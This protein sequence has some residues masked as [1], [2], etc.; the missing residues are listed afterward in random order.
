M[1]TIRLE[2]GGNGRV[3]WLFAWYHWHLLVG[4][5]FFRFTSDLWSSKSERQQWER[6]T[7]AHIRSQRL[8]SAEWDSL[9]FLPV[10][11]LK[12]ERIL[13][14]RGSHRVDRCGMFEYTLRK[15]YSPELVP[16]QAEWPSDLCDCEK[17]KTSIHSKF[18]QMKSF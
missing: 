5:E 2:A 13:S 16:E 3:R 7:M 1:Q 14:I 15:H 12:R 8:S 11:A 10:S 6:W 4:L 17:F 18:I 9:T